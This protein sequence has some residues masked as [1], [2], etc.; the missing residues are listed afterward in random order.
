MTVTIGGS[1]PEITF[2]DSTVQNT[3][4]L[5]LTGGTLTGA[6]TP[7]TTAGI[8]GTTAGD[9]ANAG[10]VGEVISVITNA[11]GS[12]TSGTATTLT[13]ITLTA[14]DWDVSGA[15]AFNY[16]TG[17]TATTI[18]GKIT[19]TAGAF[20]LLLDGSTFVFVGATTISSGFCA[21]VPTTR[22]NITT[23]TTVYLVSY[24]YF[25]GGSMSYGGSLIARRRR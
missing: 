17:T 16:G 25:S 18:Y 3:A 21:N 10:S 22:I 9:N 5:P 23:T 15:L 6:L 12:M 13:S 2:A 1:S 20:S 14:G 8:V 24:C 4:A 19:T 7:S 11:S